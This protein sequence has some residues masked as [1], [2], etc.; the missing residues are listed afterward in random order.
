M[1]Y[2]PSSLGRRSRR[3]RR[4]VLLVALA[5]ALGLLA[6]AV[7]Y[8]TEE[9][10]MTAY[11]A[12]AKD[13]AED[14]VQLS[15]DLSDLIVSLSDAERF[16]VLQRLESLG[17]QA[18]AMHDTLGEA[19]VP[20]PG[21]EIHGFL[22]VAT[23]AWSDALA[24]LDDAFVS[25]L[26]EPDD[27]NGD[28]RLVN[29]FQLLRLGDRSYAEF[30]VAVDELERDIVAD[31]YPAV[32][33]VGRQR[34]TLYDATVIGDRLRIVRNL[35]QSHDISVTATIEPTPVSGTGAF[36]VVPFADSINIK[37]VVGNEGNLP[38]EDI[39]VTLTLAAAGRTG[40]EGVTL[41]ET[42]PILDPG[43]ATTIE[44]TAIAVEPGGLYELVISTRVVDD[45]D[46]ANSQFTIV[47]FVNDTE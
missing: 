30:L 20:R 40:G 45:A 28:A 29:A 4:L 43:V 14:G 6:L 9:R 36:P 15:A 27:A 32:E 21:A 22:M 33:F 46:P 41:V 3:R 13:V 12:L 24:S 26:D 10:D 31:D 44:F 42:I 18:Q 19:I 1:A 37:A 38:E 25:I 8:R 5:V 11:L 2:P 39:D 23:S 17:T 47:F 35:A 7:R 16:N 34:E